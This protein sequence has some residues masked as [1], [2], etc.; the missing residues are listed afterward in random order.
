MK[1]K[2]AIAVIAFAGVFQ[3]VTAAQAPK[4]LVSADVAGGNWV[5]PS[6]PDAGQIKQLESTNATTEKKQAMSAN[7]AVAKHQF[8]MTTPLSGPAQ[9]TTGEIVRLGNMSSRPWTK[10]VGWHPGASGFDTAENQEPQLRLIS[11]NF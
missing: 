2:T 5:A 9:K 10:I 7:V 1:T 6:T 8:R 11:V 3:L 4:Q